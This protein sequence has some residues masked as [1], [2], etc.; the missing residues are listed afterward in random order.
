MIND[1]LK[2]IERCLDIYL[3]SVRILVEMLFGPANLLALTFEMISI[4][5][6][7]VQGKMENECWLSGGK[8]SKNVLNENG[9]SDRNS[10]ANEQK[11]ISKYLQLFA[12]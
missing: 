7:F 9:T 8:Y 1:I 5:S 12:D 4:I 11:K 2:K 6:S 3:N 10:G